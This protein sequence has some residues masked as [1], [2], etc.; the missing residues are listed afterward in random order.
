MLWTDSLF[1]T[2]TDLTRIDSEALSVASAEQIAVDGPNGIIRASIEDASNEILKKIISFGGYLNSGDLTANHLAAVL[3]VGIG[4]SVRQKI[5]LEQIVVTGDVPGQWNWI[6]QW[7]VHLTL[8]NLYRNASSRTTNDRYKGRWDYFKD[9]MRRRFEANLYALG[10]PVV[11][12]PMDRPAAYFMFNSGTWNYSNVSTV[13]GS[14]TLNN[15]NVDVAITYLDNSQP[16]FY[17]S[18]TQ[19]NQSESDV[20]DLITTAMVTG[21]VLQVS[22]AGLNPPTGAQDPSQAMVVVVATH[23]ATSWNIYCGP[24]G[25]GIL[26]LQ[27]SSPIPIATTQYTLAGD[28]VFSGPTQLLGQRQDRR[29]SLMRMRQRA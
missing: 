16:N 27:N 5:G 13:S 8:C 10:I 26:Y 14:G 7:V 20:S 24:S 15:V 2:D 28:P 6:K 21:N 19:R 17:V 1:V 29:L 23:R 22:L 11:I 18:P 4:N 25:G 9:E 3:N 12:M